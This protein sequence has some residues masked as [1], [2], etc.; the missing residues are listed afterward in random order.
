MTTRRVL[1]GPGM[2]TT[3]AVGA[4]ARR[5]STNGAC[6]CSW[7]PLARSPAAAGGIIAEAAKDS[8]LD[9]QDASADQER[10]DLPQWRREQVHASHD[11][12]F[13][14]STTHEFGHNYKANQSW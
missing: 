8:L 14:A 11:Q 10:V 3:A 4:A 13:T 5:S 1:T 9:H 6:G 12:R 7:E 2:A